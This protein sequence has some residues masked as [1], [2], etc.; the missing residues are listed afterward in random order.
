MRAIPQPVESAPMGKK[1]YKKFRLGVSM[2]MIH[3]CGEPIEALDRITD[4]P[5]MCGIL[6]SASK[7]TL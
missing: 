4:L 2:R 6:F 3:G 7:N 1:P 5:S